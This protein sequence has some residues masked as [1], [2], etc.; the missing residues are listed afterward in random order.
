MKKPKYWVAVLGAAMIASL[1]LSGCP[2]Q[3]SY[4]ATIT[5]VYAATSGGG[6]FVYTGSAT[7]TN[8]TAAAG[9]LASNN[10]TGVVV[11]GSGS[12]AQVF[13][14]TSGS[15]VSGF[16]GSTWVTW[17]AAN[18]LGGN[19]INRLVLGSTLY[20]ATSGGV[21]TYNLDGSASA[22]T[23]DAGSGANTYPSVNDV[24]SYG[25]YTYIAA[26]T[27]LFVVNG[28]GL[29]KNFTPVAVTGAGST[30]V[31]AVFVDF[32]LDIIAGTDRGLAELYA[33]STSFGANLLPSGT[34]VRQICA[35]ASGN[36]YAATTAGLYTI[37]TNVVLANS[38]PANCVCVDGAGTIYVGTGTGLLESKDG[39]A[40]WTTQLSGQAVTSVVTTA[41]LYTF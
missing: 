26:G 8:Y 31:Q 34:S 27:G 28:T 11:S 29:E 41:P 14:G 25:N 40:T 35:D 21:S 24:F 23:N 16:D 15:G 39:G 18:G 10:L 1:A 38:T 9:G 5:P 2:T 6:L 12:G 3:P 30:A 19:T 36:L 4:P 13:V 32:A 37:G 17:K 20:A 22:W 33:G 7:W